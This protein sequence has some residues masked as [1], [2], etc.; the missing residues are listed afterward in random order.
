MQEF[1]QSL[2]N[3]KWVAIMLSISRR[4]LM[5]KVVIFVDSTADL[6]PEDYQKND[7]CVVPLLVNIGEKTY[8]DGSEINS[9]LLYKLV[10]EHGRLTNDCSRCTDC[11][12]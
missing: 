9:Q 2:T 5:N 8:K 4:K 1:T 10:E 7:I 11:L 12:Y 6:N 3:I